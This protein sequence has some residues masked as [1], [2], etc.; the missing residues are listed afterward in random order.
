MELHSRTVSI[1]I[2]EID[3]RSGRIE[4]FVTVR[5]GRNVAMEAVWVRRSDLL[6]FYSQVKD[7]HFANRRASLSSISGDFQIDLASPWRPIEYIT[8]TVRLKTSGFP[9]L[10]LPFG[11]PTKKIAPDLNV[12]WDI[13]EDALVDWSSTA[14]DQ[15]SRL[16]GLAAEVEQALAELGCTDRC[17][18][19][20]RTGLPIPPH[21]LVLDSAG[22][23]KMPSNRA[24]F[25]AAM[26]EGKTF[27][28]LLIP[29]KSLKYKSLAG[30]WCLAADS[31]FIGRPD[32]NYP[33]GDIDR[34]RM[35]ELGD[36][37]NG[38]DQLFALDYRDTPPLEPRVIFNRYPQDV[39]RLPDGLPASRWVVLAD[40][41]EE[42][43]HMIGID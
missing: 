41:I 25:D 23:W 31:Q 4:L 12:A 17:P 38:W 15:L 42:F 13:T 5:D 9:R 7:I 39:E 22:L 8:L 1:E 34:L 36:M 11:I 20:S 30:L 18:M 43:T 26:G 6:T 28:S 35:I 27:D 32:P 19:F 40:R 24:Q 21:I 2:T 33:P 16:D 29:L 10:P 14:L 37:G 3:N